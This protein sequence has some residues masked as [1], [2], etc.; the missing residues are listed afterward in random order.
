MLIFI[1]CRVPNYMK[2][3]QRPPRLKTT[4]RLVYITH[5]AVSCEDRTHN[6]QRIGKNRDDH[7]NRCT[8]SA[9]SCYFNCFLRR[10]LPINNN[11]VICL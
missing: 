9:I 8:I 11:L 5:S 10:D 7:F 1:L 3:T 6:I 4:I 2:R